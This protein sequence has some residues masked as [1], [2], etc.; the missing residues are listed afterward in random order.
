VDVHV[1]PYFPESHLEQVNVS[2]IVFNYQK[3]G[4][5]MHLKSR[6]FVW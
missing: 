6:Y 4:R 2:G 1:C 5:P 3:F